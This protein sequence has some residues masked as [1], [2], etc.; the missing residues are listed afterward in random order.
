MGEWEAGKPK[1][2]QSLGLDDDAM[3]DLVPDMQLKVEEALKVL[4]FSCVQCASVVAS[5]CPGE[6]SVSLFFH[7]RTL[8]IILDR[9]QLFQWVPTTCPTPMTV[10]WHTPVICHLSLLRRLC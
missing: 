5:L 8:I 7:A 1:W 6:C 2:V 10:F 4:P 9:F 3:P